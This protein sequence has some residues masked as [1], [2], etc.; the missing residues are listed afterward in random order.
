MKIY[1]LFATNNI[2]PDQIIH[3]NSD[4]S[5]SLLVAKAKQFPFQQVNCSM[6]YQAINI[7]LYTM[8]LA[9]CGTKKESVPSVL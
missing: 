9:V 6:Y 1:S 7:R 4:W 3:G 2:S 5:V 8:L